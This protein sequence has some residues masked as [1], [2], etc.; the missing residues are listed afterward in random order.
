MRTI[1]AVLAALAACAAADPVTSGPLALGAGTTLSGKGLTLQGRHGHQPLLRVH[2]GKWDKLS[3]C[4]TP[5]LTKDCTPVLDSSPIPVSSR[6]V[7]AAC[8]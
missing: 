2:A 4:H 3:M 7:N 8:Q 1:V 6:A 5:A